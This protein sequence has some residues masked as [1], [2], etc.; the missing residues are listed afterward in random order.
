M[1]GR[2]AGG[3]DGAAACPI[4]GGQMVVP[5]RGKGQPEERQDGPGS[6]LR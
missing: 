1:A 5:G 2:H 4:K 3:V 6:S